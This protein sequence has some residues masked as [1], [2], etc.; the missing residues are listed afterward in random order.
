MRIA[1]A[2]VVTTDGVFE[3]HCV[4]IVDGRITSV[5]P[6]NDAHRD[7]EAFDARGAVLVPGFIDMHMHGALGT[8]LMEMDERHWAKV[9]NFAA[10]HGVTGFLATA[11][12]APAQA[13][14]DFLKLAARLTGDL[15]GAQLL[16]AHAE[17]PYLNPTYAGMMPEEWLR[18]P[19][20]KEYRRWFDT[21]VVRRMTAALELPGGEKLLADAGAAGVLLSL[22]HTLCSADDVKRWADK[23]LRH[24][25]HL[26]NAMSRAE[27]R[28]PVRQCGAVEGIL[29]EPRVAA[30][31]IGDGNHVPEQL[32]RVATLCKGEAGITI[33]SDATPSTGAAVEGEAVPYGGDT[34]QDLIVRD[35]MAVSLDG[36]MLVGSVSTLGDMFGRIVGWLDGDLVRA[37][38]FFATNAAEAMGIADKKGRI[39]RGCDADLVLL[40]SDLRVSRTWVGGRLVF[41]ASASASAP[42]A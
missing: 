15:P 14:S 7:D 2:R 4:D 5:A 20:P 26:Y 19:E 23:G 29:A 31:L 8:D 42:G 27:K 18:E 24:A 25:T 13:L 37:A 35:G 17:G 11:T 12:S 28:G 1:N 22:G 34:G 10:A 3:S 30:E 40:D 16:G 36:A 38:R 32:F 39:A 33:A 41:D 21:G 6:D 9:S